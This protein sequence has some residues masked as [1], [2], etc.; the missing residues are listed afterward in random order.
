LNRDKEEMAMK[1]YLTEMQNKPFDRLRANGNLLFSIGASRIFTFV[2]YPHFYP[3]GVRRWVTRYCA[4]NLP[5]A[6]GG[7]TFGQHLSD[8]PL[9]KGGLGGVFESLMHRESLIKCAPFM[10]RQAHHERN[11]KFTVRPEPV[12]GLVQCFH[13]LKPIFFDNRMNNPVSICWSW[14]GF[15]PIGLSGLLTKETQP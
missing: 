4:A 10:D 12:E 15:E 2:A 1:K 6:T 13:K 5:L 3:Q 8:S 9:L 14:W 11:Q 7:S